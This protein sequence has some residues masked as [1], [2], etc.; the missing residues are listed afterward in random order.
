VQDGAEFFQ[1]YDWA[2]FHVLLKR[3]V[4]PKRYY[5]RLNLNQE[6][7]E[8]DWLIEDIAVA[9]EAT[10]M[11]GDGGVGKTFITMAMA[12]AVAGCDKT[13]L[14]LA[15]K[16]HGPVLYVDEE[17]SAQL[18]LQRLH[19]LGYDPRRH[20]DLDYL[21]YAGVDLLNEP[22]KL[23]EEAAEIEPVLVIID[24]LSRVAI[25]AEE[26]SNPDMTKFMQAGVIPIARETGAAVLLVHH[27]SQTGIAP[28]GAT[29][30]RNSA[31]QVLSIVAAQDKGG[32]KTGKLNI[33]PS[34]PRRNTAHF[35]A[36]IV[37]DIEQ[38]G[39]VRVERAEE[40]DPF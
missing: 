1:S 21:W 5:K 6:V 27:T 26:N 40:E 11:A 37:G 4:E 30:I 36:H 35:Q 33:F 18:V 22:E 34:K 2:A 25:G 29:A 28:R 3:A 8:T 19:A 13:F 15:V 24:S 14:D 20:A 17:N 38:D 32:V 10:V 39:W 23:R 7:P 31:D 16:K 12:L 9:R